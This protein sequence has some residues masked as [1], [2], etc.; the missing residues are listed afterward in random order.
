MTDQAVQ[1]TGAATGRH[2][3]TGRD[4]ELRA[5]RED[6]GRVGLHTLSGHPLPHSRVL[7]IAGAPGSG[8]TALAEEFVRRIQDRYPGGVLRARLTDPGG[9]PVPTERTARDLLAA[10][11]G[12]GTPAGA[13]R[14]AAP[15]PGADEEDL[16]EAVRTALAVRGPTVLLLDDVADSDQVLD[17]VPDSRSA[18]SSRWPR[19]R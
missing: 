19:A 6:I 15:P 2:A 4:R 3:F 7:L 16:S 8:R 14:P 17:L 9:L 5:L 13:R 12:L 1:P 10:L 11:A 18:S